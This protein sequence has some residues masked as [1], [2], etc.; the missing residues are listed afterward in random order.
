MDSLQ[1]AYIATS[2]LNGAL[3]AASAGCGDTAKSCEVTLVASTLV[4]PYGLL[5]EGRSYLVTGG[6]RVDRVDQDGNVTTITNLTAPSGSG[7]LRLNGAVYVLDNPP[8]KLVRMNDGWTGSDVATGLQNPVDLDI[9]GNAF[10]VSDYDNRKGPPGGPSGNNGRLL[11]VQLDGRVDV[12]VG[13]GLG[14]PGAVS[15]QPEG[16]FVPDYD[17]GRL[18]KIAK[19][20]GAITE[21]AT[22]LG[23]PVAIRF[24]D[25]AFYITDFAGASSGGR[26]LR[27]TKSGSVTVLPVSGIGASAGLVIDGSD[28]LVTDLIGGQLFRISNCLD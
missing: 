24:H 12:I 11:R 22:G 26:L 27:V 6:G 10:I 23:N 25:G 7:L 14:G 16:Y 8:G 17:Q 9:D 20:T 13:S 4:A 21:V 15:V 5:V 3:I 19:D 2:L 1:L 28:M 18:L